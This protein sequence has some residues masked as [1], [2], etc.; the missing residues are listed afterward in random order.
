MSEVRCLDGV[1][2]IEG[3]RDPMFTIIISTLCYLHFISYT[4]TLV[5]F[6]AI[7]L[8][9][10]RLS[11][12]I[13]SWVCDSVSLNVGSVSCVVGDITDN[14]G[15]SVCRGISCSIGSGVDRLH[16]FV[17][18]SSLFSHGLK[19]TL[20]AASVVRM[21]RSAPRV[22]TCCGSTVSRA[23]FFDLG[24]GDVSVCLKTSDRRRIFEVV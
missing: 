8:Y 5:S 20:A 23:S 17:F 21:F 2:G 16:D 3:V 22:R 11:S 12:C 4:L 24:S 18:T 13:V 7:G 14:V 9:W 19:G 10:R 1:V 6:C 15:S